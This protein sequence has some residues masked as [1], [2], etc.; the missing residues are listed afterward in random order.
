MVVLDFPRKN[1]CRLCCNAGTC[2]ASFSMPQNGMTQSF[3]VPEGDS[4]AFVTVRVDAIQSEEVSG[5]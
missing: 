2:R 1:L 4:L 3:G 5:M